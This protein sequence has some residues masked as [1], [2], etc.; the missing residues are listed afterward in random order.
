M[1]LVLLL[2]LRHVQPAVRDGGRSRYRTNRLNTLGEWAPDAVPR[3]RLLNATTA[4]T[5]IS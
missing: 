5:L 4:E 1:W 2:G 3:I